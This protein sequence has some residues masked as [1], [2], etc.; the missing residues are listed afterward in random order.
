L[1]EWR[2]PINY[3]AYTWVLDYKNGQMIA[4]RGID[5]VQSAK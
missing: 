2:R 1:K 5:F 3:R 4:R